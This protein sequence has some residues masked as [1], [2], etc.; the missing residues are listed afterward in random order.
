MLVLFMISSLDLLFLVGA[1]KYEGSNIYVF[2]HSFRDVLHKCV[3]IFSRWIVF[4][5]FCANVLVFEKQGVVIVNLC[6]VIAAAFF[7]RWLACRGPQ[8][9]AA[10]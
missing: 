3:D 6:A 9:G 5:L 1:A 8:K 10:A 4:R 2:C 7:G